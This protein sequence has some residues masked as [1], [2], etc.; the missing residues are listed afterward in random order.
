[1]NKIT[2]LEL[3]ADILITNSG[4]RQGSSLK[5]LLTLGDGDSQLAVFWL[6]FEVD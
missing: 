4:R 6:T 2:D 3:S 1:M 5:R